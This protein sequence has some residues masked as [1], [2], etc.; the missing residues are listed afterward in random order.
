[1]T[2]KLFKSMESIEKLLSLDEGYRVFKDLRGSPPY[3][4]RSKKE[5]NICSLHRTSGGGTVG[6]GGLAPQ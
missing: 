1:M 4:E 3:W 5:L 6:A 2:A